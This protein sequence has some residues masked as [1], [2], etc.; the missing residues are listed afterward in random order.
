MHRDSTCNCNPPRTASGTPRGIIADSSSR[1][2][3]LPGHSVPDQYHHTFP[4]HPVPVS[5]SHPSPTARSELQ[6]QGS[7]RADSRPHRFNWDC[8][9][10]H[11]IALCRPSHG[12]LR[13]VALRRSIYSTPHSSCLSHPVSRSHSS[14]ATTIS[15][16]HSECRRSSLCWGYRSTRLV[17]C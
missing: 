9:P 12:L 7:I 5:L 16:N 8:A 14:R 17:H 3:H 4:Y 6:C 11:H 10:L 1:P 2:Q 13:C 15:L